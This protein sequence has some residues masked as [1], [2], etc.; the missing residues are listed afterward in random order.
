MMEI[1]YQQKKN[2]ATYTISFSTNYY[3]YYLPEAKAPI[4]NIGIDIPPPIEA[5][6]DPVPPGCNVNFIKPVEACP[7]LFP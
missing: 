1:I 6:E 4:D 2:M 7:F 5:E 3:Y